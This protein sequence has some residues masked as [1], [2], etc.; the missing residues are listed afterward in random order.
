MIDQELFEEFLKFHGYVDEFCDI[1]G[2][3][4]QQ[5]RGLCKRLGKLKE[6]ENKIDELS[7]WLY[8]QFIN[9]GCTCHEFINKYGLKEARLRQAAKRLNKK[10]YAKIAKERGM[11]YRAKLATNRH[12]QNRKNNTIYC[13]PITI[14][15]NKYEVSAVSQYH[16]HKK[17]NHPRLGNDSCVAIHRLVV[18]SQIGRI[19]KKSEIVHHIDF[20]KHNNHENNLLVLSSDTQHNLLQAYLMQVLVQHVSKEDLH[21]ITYYLKDVVENI[22][23]GRKITLRQLSHRIPLFDNHSHLGGSIEPEI[24]AAILSK[25]GSS[26]I[27]IGKV[28]KSMTY[29]GKKPDN[30]AAFIKKFEM[31]NQVKWTEE[32]IYDS[33]HQVVSKIDMDGVECSEIR[34]SIGKYRPHLKMSDIEIIKL[35]KRAF[36]DAAEYFNVKTNLVLSFR[37]NASAKSLAV[38]RQV[39]KY[40]DCVVGI[41]VSGDEKYMNVSKFQDVYDIWKKNGKTLMAHVGEQPETSQHVRDAIEK[42]GITRVAHGIYSDKYTLDMA[43]DL[44]ICFDLAISSNHYTGVVKHRHTHPALRMLNNGNIITI[45]TDD[46]AVFCTSLRKEYALVKEYWCL[47]DSD[48]NQLK[49]NAIK[50][51]T[52][53][54][55]YS[56]L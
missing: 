16:L 39:D 22:G 43:R 28:R 55:E 51:S 47:S 30:F 45:G 33:V 10:D 52:F 9:S 25:H 54:C 4:L 5:I 11:C 12:K 34:F 7:E 18:E 1:H 27:R 50:H 37:H 53:N 44:G 40:A 8:D 24:V 17:I 42:W 56:G 36:D 20:D 48:I 14:G 46:A 23:P 6:Y 3:L 19:L 38:A 21:K 2:I 49:L 41:D 29:Q 13:D 31:L 32:D 35:I 26:N 15:N